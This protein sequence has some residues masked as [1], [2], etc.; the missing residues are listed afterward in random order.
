MIVHVCMGSSCYLKGSLEIINKIDELQKD[1]L[2][3]NLFGQLC[4]SSCPEGIC[5]KIGNELITGVTPA[6]IENILKTWVKD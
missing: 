6:N 3:V 2:E 4:F 5:I 1:G